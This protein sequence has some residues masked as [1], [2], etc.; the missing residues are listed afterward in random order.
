MRISDFDYDLPDTLIAQEPL[1]ERDASRMLVLNRSTGTWRDSTFREFTRELRADD[2]VVVNNSRV[3]P[4]RLI[5]RRKESGGRVE[6]FLVREISAQVWQVLIRPSARLRAGAK[7]VFGNGELEAELID[8]PGTELRKARF[9]CD[10]PFESVLE[11]IG[12]TPLPPYIRRPDGVSLIDNERYQTIYSKPRGAIAAPTAGLHFT[13]E[14][15][16]SLRQQNQLVEITLHV[17]YGTFEPVRVEDVNEHQVSSERLEILPDVAQQINETRDRG[18]RIVAV[19]TTTTR[20]LESAATENGIV[21][22]GKNEARLTITP[23]YRFRVVDALLT[24]FHLPR[25]SLLVLVSSFAG[26]ELVLQAYRHAVAE[27]Y[28]FYSYGDCML[29]L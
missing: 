18:G 24:N 29:I 28:R 27:R 5:G 15:L 6:I 17:G 1:N 4:A 12:T 8:E 21:A 20:A 11:Q 14:Q 3:I 7:V 10:E 9:A 19:G 26:R 16:T 25:S 22:A 13:D 23:A 2:L